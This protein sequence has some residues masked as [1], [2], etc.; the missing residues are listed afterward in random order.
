VLLSHE[1]MGAML[2]LRTGWR[3]A[4]G[5]PVAAL[6]RLLMRQFDAIVVTSEYARREFAAGISQARA[7]LHQIALGVDLA[8]FRPPEAAATLLDGE[9]AQRPLRLVHSG[10]LSREKTPHLAIA[11]AVE[12]HARG[13]PIRM[14]VYG[15]G[16][17][18]A[19]LERL[20]AGRPIF[21]HGHVP[22]RAALSARLARADIALSV[23]PSETFG[24]SVLEALASGT[25]VVT[26]DTGGARELV[27]EFCGAWAAPVPE[28]I[29]DSV[30][31]L[32]ARPVAERRA[33]AR[34]RAEQYPWEST[35]G[36]MLELHASLGTPAALSAPA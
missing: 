19:E 34:R 25:P 8:T 30:L 24:L 1:R 33:A 17:Q 16:P 5:R 21:F 13:V 28:A 11:A 32:A 4:G 26:A 3:T 10:R 14:D 31:E 29:A 27:D 15:E 22:G 9:R 36:S 2:S 12:L 7:R 20:A 18:R 23:C 6:N 35:I